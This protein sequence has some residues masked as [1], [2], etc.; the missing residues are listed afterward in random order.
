MA[1][2]ISLDALPGLSATERERAVQILLEVVESMTAADGVKAGLNRLASLALRATGADRCAIFV[3]DPGGLSRLLPAA[4]ASRSGDPRELWDK[5]RRMEPIDAGAD[6]RRLLLQG[7]PH[8]VTLDDAAGSPLIPESWKREWGA[9]SLAF[10][11]LRAGGE[12]YGVLAVDYV[13]HPHAFTPG[14]ASLLEAIASAAGVAL[15]S[16][17][18]VERLQ[19]AVTVE[20]RLT[21][22]S[23]ALLSGHSLAEVLDVV[24]DRF[25]SLLP[26]ATCSIN[27][28]NPDQTS[29][30]SVAFRGVPPR[31]DE[32][33]IDELPAAGV[34]EVRGIWERD[35]RRTVVIPDL[36]ALKAWGEVIPPE[37]GT[38][39]LVPLSD[40]DQV[41]GFVSV[42]RERDPFTQD[43]VQ[44]AGAFAGQA[45]LAVAQARLT[46]AL[47]VRLKVIEAL[48]RLS[49]VVV[50]TSDLKAVLAALNRGIC[51]EVGVEC[52]RV[53][54]GDPGLASMLRLPPA[55]DS[56][57]AMIRS[58]GRRRPPEPAL[59]G[60]ELAV[61]IRMENRVA[62]IL[63]IR[64]RTALDPTGLELVR[65]IAAG[66]G[67]VA[68]KA[69]LRR[70]VER[71]S[72]ELAVAAERERIARDLHDT[73]GQAFYGIGL[74][75]QD[76]LCEVSDP[77]LRARLAEL[78][79]LAARGVADVR[80]AVYALSFLHVRA[81]GFVPSLRALA[82][83]FTRAT[84]VTAELRVEGRVPALSEEVESA[85]YR[86]AHEALVNV[87]RHA[88]ATGVVVSLVARNGQA[89]LA[90]RDDGVG[91]DQRQV[92]DWQSAA[93][94]GMRTMAKS[95]EEVGGRFHVS[96]ALPRGLLIRGIIPVEDARRRAGR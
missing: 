28:L 60:G 56:E 63:S 3:R 36:K 50:R 4:G 38:G 92:A 19:R 42:G 1:E 35:P 57:L 67:E 84:G 45:A 55:S 5:F 16:A 7:T 68:Y 52:V 17:R 64:A 89:E 87:D 74:K 11:T 8:A 47:H 49:D 65:A 6:P 44:L 70:T 86:M 13:D 18:L 93:H 62:G 25:A 58:W 29:F 23:A 53:S 2:T 61:P 85:L 34:A 14:E 81:R 72:R 82:R 80:S 15:R 78:R 96:A 33:R 9:K 43:E 22:C 40:Q 21:E 41:I 69:K 66:L 37:I 32:I 76:A 91:L 79:E 46:D 20:R 10:A 31:K 39:M 88:R 94:I 95:I 12:V 77:E 71:R 75:L 24:A 26:G 48:Y 54:F 83:Q 51:A 90:V 73:V 59:V 30:R 27:L